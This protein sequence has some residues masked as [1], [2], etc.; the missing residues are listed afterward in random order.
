[1]ARGGGATHIESCDSAP[2]PPGRS[3]PL[4]TACVGSPELHRL[5]SFEGLRSVKLLLKPQWTHSVFAVETEISVMTSLTT[6]PG[7]HQPRVSGA[8]WAL[9]VDANGATQ[10]QSKGQS[11]GTVGPQGGWAPSWFQALLLTWK[12]LRT[13]SITSRNLLQVDGV[14]EEQ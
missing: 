2:S 9:G 10:R 5:V 3:Q 14:S 11:R 13:P 12:A 8:G 4:S 7:T 6:W 1:M